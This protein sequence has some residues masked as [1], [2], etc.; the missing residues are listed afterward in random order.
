[1]A[2]KPVRTLVTV[3]MDV[4][5]FLAIVVVVRIVVEFSGAL[6]AAAWGKSLL[7]V[8]KALVVPFGIKSIRTPYGGVFDI[9]AT[10]TVIVLLGLEWALGLARGA[11]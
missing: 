2:S 6:A 11:S 5:V 8:T 7:G 3:V 9:G 1:V 4:L 10:L